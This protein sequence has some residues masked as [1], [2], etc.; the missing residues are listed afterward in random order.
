MDQFLE[1][2]AFTANTK[3]KRVGDRVELRFSSGT[4]FQQVYDEAL[5]AQRRSF[6]QEEHECGI[7]MR[8]LLGDRFFFLQGCGHYFCTECLH[9]VVT[10]AIESGRV[11]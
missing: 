9:Q 5:L 6:N 3:F 7:C 11:D 4:Q 8:M 10:T 1:S 2:D